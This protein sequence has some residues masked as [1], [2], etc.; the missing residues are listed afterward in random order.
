MF[1]TAF[2]EHLGTEDVRVFSGLNV[3]V[4][5][6]YHRDSNTQQTLVLE[7][8][9]PF[10]V[11][12]NTALDVAVLQLQERLPNCLPAPLANL[13]DVN[14]SA[15]VHLIGHSRGLYKSLSLFCERCSESLS[16][17]RP[18]IRS[19]FMAGSSGSPGFDDNGNLVMM[20]TDGVS[21]GKEFV[22]RQGVSMMAVYNI[23]LRDSPNLLIE[24]GWSLGQVSLPVRV[25]AF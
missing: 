3:T 15:I 25:H 23:L 24:F 14:Q 16:P 10:I 19:T 2:T 12:G 6:N 13:G 11:F 22:L 20:L 5:F 18:L 8:L 21:D 4:C 7:K 17:D 9:E 1:F